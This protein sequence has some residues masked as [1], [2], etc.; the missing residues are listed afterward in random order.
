MNISIH[1][2][3]TAVDVPICMSIED[4]RMATEEDM[5]LQMLKRYI[6]RR[7]PHTRE[8]LGPGVEKYLL[9]R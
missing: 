3:N 6:I 5:E 2:I 7:W 9:I 4:I 8:V 1:T